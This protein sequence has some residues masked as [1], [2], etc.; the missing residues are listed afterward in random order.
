M[1][2][3]NASLGGAAGTYMSGSIVVEASLHEL[4]GLDEEDP[5]LPTVRE[6]SLDESLEFVEVGDLYELGRAELASRGVGRSWS[7]GMRFSARCG[8]WPL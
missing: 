2:E 6:L 4:D 3:Q 5:K 1:L 8:Q 7:G